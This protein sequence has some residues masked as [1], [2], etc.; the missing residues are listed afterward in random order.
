MPVVDASVW[1]SLCHAADTHHRTSKEWLAAQVREG[2][3]LTAPTLLTVEV[4]AAIRRL[5]GS[6]DL[7]VAAA[8]ALELEG[9]IDLV[10]LDSERSRRASK[11]AATES[12]RG[13]DA[14]YLELV[15]Q[16][17]D[18]LVTWDRQHLE[19]GARVARVERPS[20]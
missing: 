2:A 3:P 5:T 14:V 19:R 20:A 7:A 1:V 11:I 12:V 6:E 13:A 17:G 15:A 18:V 8:S 9:L 10:P 4:A 16:R